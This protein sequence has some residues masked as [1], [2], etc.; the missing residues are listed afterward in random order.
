MTLCMGSET[1][2]LN[3]KRMK[4]VLFCDEWNPERLQYLQQGAR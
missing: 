1:L 3:D 2:E 4:P